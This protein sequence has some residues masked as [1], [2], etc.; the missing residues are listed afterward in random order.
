[1]ARVTSLKEIALI[2][3]IC[4]S[5]LCVNFIFTL[6]VLFNKQ[7]QRSTNLYL[8]EKSMTNYD[9]AFH[10]FPILKVIP[11]NQLESFISQG[12]LIIKRYS[13]NEIIH[14]DG[15]QCSNM[16]IILAG[17]VN[18]ERI[19]ED[20]N[21]M[22]VAAFNAGNCLGANLL[23]STWPQNSKRQIESPVSGISGVT[24]ESERVKGD[25]FLTYYGSKL[26][27]DFCP[28]GFCGRNFFFE[29]L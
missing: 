21:L 29:F 13:P 18:V 6:Q 8:K 11:S 24:N 12:T 15:D 7:H 2:S 28:F 22:T 5:Q 4:G 14:F 19:D 25:I 23:F 17:E 9:H 27:F 26:F 3:V 10:T 16:E 20:G 1:M